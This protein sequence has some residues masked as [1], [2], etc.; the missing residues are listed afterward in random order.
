VAETNSSNLPQLDFVESSQSSMTSRGKPEECVALAT[1]TLKVTLWLL[2]VAN[3]VL[4]AAD[5]ASEVEVRNLVLAVKL[6]K[7]SILQNSISAKKIS[8]K[9]LGSNFSRI[10]I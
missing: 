2:K 7:G 6:V 4:E 9:F 3:S 8:D 5:K 10:S 1:S